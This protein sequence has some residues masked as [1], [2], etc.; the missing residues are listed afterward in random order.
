MVFYKFSNSTLYLLILLIKYAFLKFY[1]ILFD[2]KY[3]LQIFVFFY[4][5]GL[6]KVAFG[7]IN[8]WQLILLFTLFLLLFMGFTALFGIIHESYYIISTDLG[9]V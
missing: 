4:L 5:V 2:C 9:P 8:I 1:S 3:V 7:Y 6:F